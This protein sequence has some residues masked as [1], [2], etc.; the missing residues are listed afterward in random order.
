MTTCND[1]QENDERLNEM[2]RWHRITVI[3]PSEQGVRNFDLQRKQSETKADQA[4]EEN[5]KNYN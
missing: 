3:K 5:K 2:S 1:D 4:K